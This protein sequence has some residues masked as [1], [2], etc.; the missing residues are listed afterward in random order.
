[1]PKP[2]AGIAGSVVEWNSRHPKIRRFN[3]WLHLQSYF[4]FGITAPIQKLYARYRRLVAKSFSSR[5]TVHVSAQYPH[6]R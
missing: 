1:M 6:V 2:S 5:Q 4:A 3:H